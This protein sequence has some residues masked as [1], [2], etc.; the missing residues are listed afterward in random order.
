MRIGEKGLAAGLCEPLVV[1]GTDK[2]HH[3]EDMAPP[4]NLQQSAR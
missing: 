3:P 4:V 2:A 1:A